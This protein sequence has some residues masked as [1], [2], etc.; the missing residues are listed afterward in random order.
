MS[1]AKTTTEPNQPRDGTKLCTVLK[2]L[3][4]RHGTTIGRLSNATGWQAH[5][6]RAALTGLRKRGYAI[7]RT[8]KDNGQASYA[9]EKA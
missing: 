7:A 4:S 6:V 9:I 3:R 5:S 8:R 1:Q 2:Q